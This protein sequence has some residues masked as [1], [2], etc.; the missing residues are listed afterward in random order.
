MI[1]KI[2]LALIIIV[3]LLNNVV[4]FSNMAELV[5]DIMKKNVISIDSSMTVQDAAKMMDDAGIGAI[6]VLENG[7]AI[8]IITERDLAR[9]IIAKGK[10]LT[11]NVKDAMSSPLIVVNPDDSVWEVAQLMKTRKIHR[12][13]AVKNNSLVGMVTTSDIIRLCSVGSD[14]EM[15]KITEQILLRMKPQ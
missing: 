7:I 9:R 3:S 6:V 13:P 11:T 12:I 15:R 14:S 1:F 5:H 10:P 2:I 8:G 4:D